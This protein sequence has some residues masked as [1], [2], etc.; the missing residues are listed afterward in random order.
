MQEYF[1]APNRRSTVK[2][3]YLATY[4][5][6]LDRAIA[7]TDDALRTFLLTLPLETFGRFADAEIRASLNMSPAGVTARDSYRE[8]I[9]VYFGNN[10]A[11]TAG[12]IASV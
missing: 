8:V 7:P 6:V 10:E 5:V 12:F 9:K 2:A 3:R 4:F 1:I 11:M